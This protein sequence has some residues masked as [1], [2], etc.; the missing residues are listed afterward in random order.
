MKIWLINPYGPIPGEG[1]RDYRFTTLGN[2]LAE[3]G[4]S[5]I[6]WTSN[7]SH[8]FKRFRSKSWLDA[9]IYKSFIIRLVPTL[10]YRKNVGLGRLISE[11]VFARN[12]FRRALIENQP[13]III[14]TDPS[15]FV[16]YLTIKLKKRFGIPIILDVFD[17]WPELFSLALPKVLRRL[18]PILFAPLYRLRKHNLRLATSVTALC[19]TYLDVAIKEAEKIFLY[20]GQAI[21]NGIDINKFRKLL[22]S[23]EDAVIL[24]N[25]MRKGNDEIWVIYAGTLGNNYDISTLLRAAII[26][27]EMD[28]N[29]KIKIAG[30]GPLR[31]RVSEF[32]KNYG[33]A[34][35]D[36]FGTLNY[37]KL[38]KIYKLCDIGLCPYAPTS[39]VAMPDK[40]YDYMA[41]G[42]P[43][44]NSLRGELEQLINKYNM[45]IQYKAGDAKSLA[46]SIDK[47]AINKSLRKEMAIN[48]Y[49]R[50]QQFDQHIQYRKFA[51]LIE[52]IYEGYL[53]I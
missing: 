53:N 30:E 45:G 49:E 31:L 21:F 29:V 5:I 34:N 10:K 25:Q 16:G 2:A 9:K 51:E 46:N 27:E 1:W 4:H 23:D 43:I 48:S 28:S 40:A 41:A 26:L 7:Y 33:P 15:Q 50:A 8:H 6:W 42:L 52:T 3:R 32:I 18:S 47:L 14:G 11:I 13:D 44:V 20:P 19:Q 35:L 17:L 24:T 38:I 37:E 39:N 36:Y 22:P 12:T